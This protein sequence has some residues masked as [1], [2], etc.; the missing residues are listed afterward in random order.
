MHD[1]RTDFNSRTLSFRL[2]PIDERYRGGKLL[3]YR[4]NH[5]PLGKPQ[6]TESQDVGDHP[7]QVTLSNLI[8]GVTYV[9]SI[10]GYTSAG[11]GKAKLVSVVCKLSIFS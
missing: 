3:G 11:E 2:E 4:I 6:D 10:A 9:V 5:H 8:P 1:W 7:E